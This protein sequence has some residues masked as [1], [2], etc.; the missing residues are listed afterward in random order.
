M[1]GQLTEFAFDLTGVRTTGTTIPSE[2]DVS[3]DAIRRRSPPEES[4]RRPKATGKAR[5]NER[6]YA[7][8]V[9][10]RVGSPEASGIDVL[11]RQEE[12]KS[13]AH[14]IEQLDGPFRLH[15]TKTLRP[16]GDTE[17]NLEHDRGN[18]SARH[19]PSHHRRQER[20]HRHDEQPGEIEGHHATVANS[21]GASRRRDLTDASQFGALSDHREVVT[22]P[23]A[24]NHP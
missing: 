3:V 8:A 21:V 6:K 7:E 13:E 9:S 12:K 10:R 1:I 16:D 2:L 5:A 4:A 22:R 17:E 24:S 19:E 18:E 14:Q 23:R 11:S 20:H 15:P